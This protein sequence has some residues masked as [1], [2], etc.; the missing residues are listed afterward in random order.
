MRRSKTMVMLFAI[1][2]ITSMFLTMMSIIQT[3]NA[4]LLNSNP[5]D[6]SSK[7]GSAN[8]LAGPL[9]YGGVKCEGQNGGTAAA[10]G[11]KSEPGSIEIHGI[12][13]SNDKTHFGGILRK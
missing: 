6:C 11:I 12:Q 10:G 8:T 4:S 3:S 1:I 13:G 5:I 9:N 7:K 2:A